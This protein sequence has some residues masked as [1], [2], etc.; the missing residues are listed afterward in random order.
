MR[1]F[2][3]SEW[4]LKHQQFVLYLIIVLM[5]AGLFA[6]NKLGRKEDPEFTFKTMVVESYWPGA[7]AREVELQLTDKLERKLQEVP[8]IDYIH[9]FSKPGES[10]L[11]IS[12]RESVLSKD[13]PQVWYQIRKKVSDIRNTLPEGTSGPFFNDEFGDTFGNLYAFTADGFSSAELKKYVD[14]ARDELLRVADVNKVDYM[15][16]QDE[17]IYVEM[18]SAKLATFG[19]NPQLIYQTLQATNAMVPA[20]TVETSSERVALRVTG[21]FNSVEAIRNIGL[22]AGGHNVRLGDVANVYRGYVDPPTMKLHFDGHE[23][24]GLAVSMRKGGDVIELGKRLDTTLQRIRS[25]LPVGI[26]VHAISDQ[27]K[28]VGESVHEFVKSLVEAV[29]IVLAVSFLSLGVRTGIVVAL[30]IPLVLAMTFLAMYAMHIDLQRVS[31]GALIIALG[32]LVDDAIIAVE[33]MALKLEQGWDRVRAATYAYTS[34]AFPMLTGTLI[35]AAG[36]MPVGMARSN[37]GEYTQSIF[38][39]VGI[40]LMLSWLVAVVFTPYLGYKLL[41]KAAHVEDEDAVYQKPFFVRFRGLVTWCIEHRFTVIL[42]T[43]AA[44]AI[45][46]GA[47]KFVPKQFFPNSDRPELMV[48]MWLPQA[49]SFEQTDSQVKLIEK[50]LQGDPNIVSVTSYVG[51]GAP[52][53]F[54]PLDQ[55][56]SNLNFAQLTVMT[57]DEHVREQVAA[58]IEGMFERDFPLV[59][60]RVSRLE[61]GPPVGYPVQFRVYGPDATKL[62]PVVD[63][64][65]E[66][67]RRNPHVRHVNTDWG[68]RVKVVRIVVDQDKARALGVSS[69]QI[70]MALQNS[71]SGVSVTQYREYDR[72]VEVVT[73]LE[74]AERTNLD[75]LRD[76]KILLPNG[77]YVVVSQ[78]GTL[79]L[80]SEDSII[81]RRNR[82]PTIAVRADVSG[83]QAPDITM[84]MWPEIKKIRDALPIG[85]GIDI[86]GSQESSNIA[87]GSIMAVMPFALLA[88]TTILMLQLQSI[89]KMVLVLLTAPLGMIGVT[90]ILAFFQVPF[91]FVAQLGVLALAGMIMRNSVILV[92]Q[93]GQ[94]M[95][96]GGSVWDAI[97]ESAVRRFRPIMLTAAAAILAMIPLTRS[98]F[99]GPMAWAIMG[100]LLVATLLTLFFLPALY[101]AW[102]RVQKP[103]AAN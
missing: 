70:S 88:M 81:W 50:R 103:Q 31:L 38:Q 82:M 75:N 52:R 14:A 21:E 101:A 95:A 90:A 44:F 102:Y 42:I 100:G 49:S 3:L 36:F 20:G 93:I 23:A 66:L 2:N 15:G 67:M 98:T 54:L 32:L 40:S 29:V 83:A 96:E 80:D 47:F 46:M 63:K 92:D 4:A 53:F 5:C 64:I 99:W 17:R 68:E 25:E 94:H 37:A 89:S 34:T 69:Q 22:N 62:W 7:S 39:V 87:Q 9:S 26:E 41:P 45:S 11:Q 13:V 77:K 59:R 35:T 24:I 86:G 84:S 60:G 51:A 8:E 30:S 85:Y 56:L 27:P 61:S 58:K 79:K 71:L 28:V 76:A 55:Q 33:M 18:S 19:I 65:E 97:V 48:D 12:L 57:R 1:G 16:V 43:V 6:Y 78:L 74:Q 91:G 10:Q 73:R 72:D